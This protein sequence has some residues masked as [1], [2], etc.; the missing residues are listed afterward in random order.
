MVD[1]DAFRQPCCFDLMRIDDNKT[2][3][4]KGE[5]RYLMLCPAG[6]TGL[7]KVACA[8]KVEMLSA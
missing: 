8:K 7:K 4:L 3:Y 6:R 2:L 5:K 1:G